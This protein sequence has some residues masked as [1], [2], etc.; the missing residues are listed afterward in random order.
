MKNFDTSALSLR[1]LRLLVEIYDSG[2]V[3]EAARRIGL[4]QSSAS[5]ALDRLREQLGDTL[6][7]RVG[8]NVEPTDFL[9]GIHPGLK[10]ALIDLEALLKG[11]EPG[12]GP[13]AKP[14]SIASNT[15]EMVGVLRRIH[16]RI[17]VEAPD[18][19][20]RYI[21][22]G[23]RGNALPILE[24]GAVDMVLCPAFDSYPVELE[25][26]S[27]YSGRF[28]CFRDPAFHK[29]DLTLQDYASATHATLDFGGN[30]PSII[31]AALVAMHAERRIVLSAA[32]SYVLASLMAGT[33]HIASMPT[34]LADAAF[35]DFA[36][37]EIPVPLPTLV[38]DMV[39]HRR[40]SHTR[41]H[42]WLAEIVRAA[43][44]GF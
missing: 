39:W 35:K 27:L 29:P 1:N 23:G 34:F 17:H 38:W 25:A 22:I 9:H 7:I 36:M 32:N 19:R 20:V 43:F 44:A 5:H 2:S 28:V 41:R 33:P 40:T 12:A 21:D 10:S 13:G 8:R 42:V 11:G 37:S 16:E 24:M 15:S 30:R 31:D 4:T 14:I 26:E 3:S 18:L 6:F